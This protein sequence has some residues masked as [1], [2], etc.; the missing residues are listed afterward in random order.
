MQDRR[1]P[2]KV[3]AKLELAAMVAMQDRRGTW[4]DDCQ[5]RACSDGGNAGSMEQVPQV[6]AVGND[7]RATCWREKGG[8]GEGVGGGEG[9]SWRV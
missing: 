3:I 1:A 5:A 4:E 8:V 9:K 2:G 6:E 7:L